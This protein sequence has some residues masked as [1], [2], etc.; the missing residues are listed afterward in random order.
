[1]WLTSLHVYPL[2]SARGLSPAEWQAGERGFD[3]DRRF[4]VV[5]PEGHFWSQRTVP[6]LALIDALPEG[7]RLRLSAPGLSLEVPLRPEGGEPRRVEVWGDEM[8]A[9]SLG[10]E[11]AHALAE[12]LGGACELVY[13][14]DESRRQVDLE[15]APPGLNV[16]F[17]DG[18]PYLLTTTASLAELA[19]LGGDVPMDRFRPNLVIDGA[20]PFEEDG[21]HELTVGEVRFRVVKPCA[22]CPIPNID[23][24]TG[25]R[26][27]EP[28]RTLAQH[29]KRDGKVYFG[30]NLIALTRGRLRVGDPVTRA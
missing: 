21:W 6:R 17:A 29:R 25:E 11:P 9:W 10:V 24:K 15:Y 7:D 26:G 23:Q 19:R 8:D 12:F 20:A 2:K 27:L 13:L 3:G 14:P 16:G 22:R 18:F 30:Q 1:M 5:G 28:T 4:M